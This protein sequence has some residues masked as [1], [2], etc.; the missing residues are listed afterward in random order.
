MQLPLKIFHFLIINWI[1]SIAKSFLWSH[2][3]I[4]LIKIVPLKIW[5]L[6]TV[7]NILLN[8]FLV[9][10]VYQYFLI[11]LTLF[12]YSIYFIFVKLFLLFY[13]IIHIFITQFK[14]IFIISYSILTKTIEIFLFFC[15]FS[16]NYSILWLICIFFLFITNI[17]DIRVERVIL[18]IFNYLVRQYISIWYEGTLYMT[19]FY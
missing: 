7:P 1:A 4:T 17:V 13:H 8:I 15:I 3:F 5:I 2:Y 11:F 14:F 10:I 16:L 18:C 19:L 6:F 9:T 12:R